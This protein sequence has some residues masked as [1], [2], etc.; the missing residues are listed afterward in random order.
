MYEK[1]KQAR[2]DCNAQLPPRE[3]LQKMTCKNKLQMEC[4]SNT[5]M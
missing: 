3:M 2:M 4:I 1:D 5:E